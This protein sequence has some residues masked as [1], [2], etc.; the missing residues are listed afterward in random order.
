VELRKFL[1]HDVVFQT[2]SDCEIILHLVRH[3]ILLSYLKDLHQ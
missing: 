1:R 2:H 3:P